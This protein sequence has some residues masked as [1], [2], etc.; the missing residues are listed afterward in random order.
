MKTV[1]RDLPASLYTPFDQVLAA[2]GPPELDVHE[3]YP[4]EHLSGA[5]LPVRDWRRAK[6]SSMRRT[7]LPA[8]RKASCDLFVGYRPSSRIVWSIL[9]QDASGT[10]QANVHSVPMTGAVQ[11]LLQ[12]LGPPFFQC[13]H[14]FATALDVYWWRREDI[15]FRFHALREDDNGITGPLK[16]GH[17]LESEVFSFSL[18]APWHPCHHLPHLAGGGA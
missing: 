15:G 2:L 12:T 6:F 9:V 10:F 18:A 14:R 8:F 13:P 5:P 1:S 17:I 11:N 4:E 7:I 3:C 16:A